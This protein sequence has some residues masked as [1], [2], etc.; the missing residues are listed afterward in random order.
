[1]KWTLH[2]EKDIEQDLIAT[3]RKGTHTHVKTLQS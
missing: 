3:L 1:M 2:I